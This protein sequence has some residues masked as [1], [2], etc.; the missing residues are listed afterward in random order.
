MVFIPYRHRHKAL[1]TA[2]LL[3]AVNV[4]VDAKNGEVYYY[5]EAKKDDKIK[6]RICL[7][8]KTLL[9]WIDLSQRMLKNGYI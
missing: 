3:H 2:G 4:Y 8:E 7:K 6:A 9:K 5:L 1:G